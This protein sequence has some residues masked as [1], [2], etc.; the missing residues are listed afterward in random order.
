MQDRGFTSKA[1]LFL[2]LGALVLAGLF[3]FRP[4]GQRDGGRD[5]RGTEAA[6][7]EAAAV[8]RG[9]I[10]LRRTFN[11]ALKAR[12][13][14]MV[15]PKVGGRIEKIFVNLADPVDRG[16][17]VAELDNDEFVQ[18]VAQAKAD[19]AVAGANLAE[20]QSALE[21]AEREFDRIGTLRKRGVASES[22]YDAALAEQAAKKARLEVARAQVMRAEALLET[23]NIRLGYTKVTADWAGGEDRRLVAERLVDEGYTVA[24]NTSLLLIAELDP[25]TGVI[26]VTEKEY[27]LLQ[28]GQSVRLATDAFP[29]ESFTG[30]IERISPVFREDTRQARIELSVANRELRL[31]PGMFIRAT[32]ELAHLEEAVIVPEQAITIRDGQAGV[33]MVNEEEMAALWRPVQ[34]GI[35]EGDRVQVEGEGL[36]GRVVTLGQQLIDDGSPV[37][38]PGDEPHPAPAAA[39]NRSAIPR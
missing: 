25:I 14:F 4:V 28:P 33:F 31:K 10:T 27:A 11:G 29:G 15:A 16:Q 12:A 37:F 21:Q 23:A 34:V 8:A 32:V 13:E 2:F 5:G 17:V 20:A 24:A 18:A 35:R 38:I 39:E 3:Y 26:H 6:P 7:V 36:A 30:R 1:I 19:L 9:P 22:Q